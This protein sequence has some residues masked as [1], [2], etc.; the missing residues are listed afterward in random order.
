MHNQLFMQ[1]AYGAD[2]LSK[3]SLDNIYAQDVA[4]IPGYIKQVTTRTICQDQ[5][6]L[7]LIV[8][9]GSQM[10]ERGMRDRAEHLHFSLEA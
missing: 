6:S 2:H 9:E 7:G 8:I 4:V 1:I 10:D 3:H 5:E